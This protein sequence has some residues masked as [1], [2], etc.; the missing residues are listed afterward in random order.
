MSPEP[1]ALHYRPA[2]HGRGEDTARRIL[3]AAIEVFAE[4]GYEGASTRSLAGRAGVNAPAI[5]YYFGSKEGLYRAVIG[6]IAGLVEARLV[7]VTTRIAAALAG[8]PAP[9]ELTALLLDLLDGFVDLVTCRGIPEA[10]ALL[11]ARAEIEN[12]AALD[13][14]QQAVMRTA[15]QPAIAIIA[16]LLGLKETDEEAKIRTF[17]IFGQ[18]VVFKKRS[19]KM[20]AC[21]ALG[22]VELD[23]G[24]IKQIGSI[25]RNQTEAILRA[26]AEHAS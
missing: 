19:T 10:A 14:L 16:R 4:E 12:A 1:K 7:P 22:W 21:P 20:G 15:F 18:A 2:S 9:P 8:Q 24:R 5:Q 17:A 26:A 3:L 13:A 23:D 6:H 25:L 11:I